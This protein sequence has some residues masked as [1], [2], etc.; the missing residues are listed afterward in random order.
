MINMFD[1]ELFILVFYLLNGDFGFSLNYGVG[2]SD[3]VSCVSVAVVDF[4]NDMDLDIY[5]VCCQGVFNLVNCYYDNQGDGIFVLVIFYGGEGFIGVGVEIGVVESVVIVDYD[6][7]GFVD[8][9][10]INGLFYYLVSFG[11]FD[12]LFKNIGNGNY[13][14]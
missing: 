4:D 11:G 7:D 5:M 8:V 9:V 13:W 10:V 1:V 3:V 12:K 2:L 14:I 6:V